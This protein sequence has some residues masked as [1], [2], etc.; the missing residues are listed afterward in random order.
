MLSDREDLSVASPVAKAGK[1]ER[2]NGGQGT[3]V[4]DDA[5]G[6]LDG[7]AP[8]DD[9]SCGAHGG[10]AA[11]DENLLLREVG[12]VLPESVRP[13]RARSTSDRSSIAM[14]RNNDA[15]PRTVLQQLAIF[16]NMERC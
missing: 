9:E 4:G 1:R 5:I 12:G 6:K 16:C 2:G 15:A 11:G 8:E 14:D 3:E 7:M 10:R 13:G